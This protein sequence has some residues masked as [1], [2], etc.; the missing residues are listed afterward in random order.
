MA[1]NTAVLETTRPAGWRTGLGNFLR[2][3][4]H[5][6]WGNR[7][8]LTQLLIWL[9]ALNGIVAI[10]LF[11]A[12]ADATQSLAR[13]A[14]GLQVFLGVAH[15]FA[16]V[17]VIILAQDAIITEKQMGTAAWVLSKPLARASFILAKVAA[18]ALG[19]VVIIVAAQGLVAYGLTMLV[20]NGPAAQLS[21]FA[22]ALGA[23]A[24]NLLFFLAL[25]LMLGT[26]FA[27]RGPVIGLPIAFLFSQQFIAAQW[28]EIGKALPYALDG[29][30]RALAAG[31]P[32]PTALP[33]FTTAALTVACIGVALWQFHRTEL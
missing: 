25:T 4:L 23:L 14:E 10:V 22:G 17:G 9:G 13:G 11:V 32:L 20:N 15:I 29:V 12:P 33:I 16:A 28:P 27:E 6:W 26:F 18:H 7:M 1:A 24:L 31:A 8:W 19:I 5:G 21:H 2:K 30:A 3:E